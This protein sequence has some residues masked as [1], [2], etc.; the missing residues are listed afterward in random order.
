[1]RAGFILH[2]GRPVTKTWYRKHVGPIARK[3]YITKAQVEEERDA[4]KARVAELEADVARESAHRALADSQLAQAEKRVAELEA[5]IVRLLTPK[6]LA[7]F[8]AEKEEG[9]K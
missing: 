6:T 2:E 1:M 3:V 8:M 9:K 4:L 7:D 5:R